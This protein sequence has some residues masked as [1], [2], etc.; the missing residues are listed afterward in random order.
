MAYKAEYEKWFNNVCEQHLLD[1]LVGIKGDEQRIKERFSAHLPFG[2]AGLRGLIGA[3]TFR[4]NRYT[5]GRATQGFA[6]Y[7]NQNGTRQNK[8]VIAY[9]SR[10]YSCEFAHETASVFA[11]NGI[12]AYVF[13]EPTGVPELSFAIRH[14]KASGGVV[15][16]A[17]HNP[18]EYNGYKA[19]AAYGGQLGPAESQT[20]MR[21]I[22][23]IDFFDGVKRIAFDE[24]IARGSIIEIGKEVDDSYYQ[25][26][27][28][29][30]GTKKADDLKV[31]YTPLHGVGLRAVKSVFPAAGIADLHIV[32]SQSKPDGCFP[33][34]EAPNPEQRSAME[35]AIALAT[36]LNA[37]VAVGTDPDADRMGAAVNSDGYRM[38]TGNQIGCILINY[39]L[40][41]NKKLSANDFIVKSFVSTGLAE[42]IAK[43]Y[44]IKCH[45][46]LTGFRYI[47]EMIAKAE[48]TENRFIFG[49]EESCGFLAGDGSRD[50]DGVLAALLFCKAAQYYKEKGLTLLDVLEKLYADYGYHAERVDTAE[51]AGIDG[52][53]K[54]QSIMANLRT[55]NVNKI[56]GLSVLI[57]EDYHNGISLPAGGGQAHLT[58]PRTDAIK[59]I[60]EENSWVCVRP[61]G[62]EPKIKL[63][64]ASCAKTGQTAMMRIKKMQEHFE[65]LTG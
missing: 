6:Q 60:L 9:D 12:N 34:I 55:D 25:N 2:T 36:K 14:L 22:E 64:Y 54:M 19:Y 65:Y 51:F 37:D 4:M 21:Q 24:G 1:E 38:L 31:V 61:S 59:Y 62:T 17:S 27:V 11:A 45:T 50:K 63:Y 47:S 49:F 56:G 48:G 42:R 35:M 10:R 44:G 33:T 13:K 3:G 18:K 53:K 20:V 26:I 58:L 43:S 5:V 41:T 23:T 30:C 52:M 29:L 57:K 40:E 32:E 7:L 16:T 28:E 8:V 46:V 39:L 15:I